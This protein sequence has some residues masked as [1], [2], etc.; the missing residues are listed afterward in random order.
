MRKRRTT[1]RTL[2]RHCLWLH[3]LEAFEL[4]W[5]GE[6]W[7]TILHAVAASRVIGRPYTETIRGA[8][9]VEAAQERVAHLI[10]L[11]PHLELAPKVR[12]YRMQD[13]LLS[14]YEVYLV[15]VT[16]KAAE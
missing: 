4:H 5:E 12:C 6:Y 11:Y 9:T 7:P 15:H 10:Q 8:P 3:S 16:T 2:E 1:L 14:W 13:I